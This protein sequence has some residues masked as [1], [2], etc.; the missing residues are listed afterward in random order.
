MACKPGR[1]LSPCWESQG[2]GKLSCSTALA[3]SDLQHLKAIQI[4]YPKLSAYDIL[5]MICWELE[6]D[7]VTQ[8]AEQLT[9]SSIMP[10]SQ[11]T[12]VVGKWCSLLMKP[13]PYRVKR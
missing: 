10:C 1:N 9:T 8:D 5:K 11:S 13:I 4:F 12:N 7:G 2:W 3:H 6:C